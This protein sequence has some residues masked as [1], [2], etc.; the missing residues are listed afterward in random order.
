MN[1]EAELQAHYRK[2]IE[3]IRALVSQTGTTLDAEGERIFRIMFYLGWEG[4]LTEVS[5]ISKLP[6]EQQAGQ[7]VGIVEFCKKG[8]KV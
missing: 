8:L 1:K 2:A 5:R 3:G 7:W 4:A 6:K